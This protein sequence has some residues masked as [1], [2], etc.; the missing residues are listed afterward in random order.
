MKYLKFIIFLL[1]ILSKC[2]PLQLRKHDNFWDWMKG[3]PGFGNAV[4]IT[5]TQIGDSIVDNRHPY[6]L[7]LRT[8]EIFFNPQGGFIYPEKMIRY[9]GKFYNTSDLSSIKDESIKKKIIDSRNLGFTAFDSGLIEYIIPYRA[10][11]DEDGR[12]GKTQCIALFSLPVTQPIRLITYSIHDVIK[13]F[14]IPIA[15]VYYTTK[16]DKEKVE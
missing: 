8:P 7:W 3:K 11:I 12:P 5:N 13:T 9:K 1:F 6:Y 14:M 15:A 4:E 16:K 2:S 10:L